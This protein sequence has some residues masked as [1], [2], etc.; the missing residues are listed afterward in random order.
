MYQVELVPAPITLVVERKSV[1]IPELAGFGDLEQNI[2]MS[3]PASFSV[4]GE[5]SDLVC[6]LKKSLY[7]L[8]QAL[9]M[10]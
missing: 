10:W 3:Q 5:E 7:G 1:L 2:Y 8:K 6:P 9:R 4:T